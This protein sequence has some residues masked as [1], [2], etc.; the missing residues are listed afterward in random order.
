[1]SQPMSSI[2]LALLA[3]Q[4]RSEN[5]DRDY[6][7]A[8]PIA[9][10]GLSCRFPGGANSPELFWQLLASGIDA[11]TEVPRDRWD[12]DALYDPA[13]NVPG[14]MST[15]YGGFIDR[16]DE[17]DAAYFGIAP[18][19]AVR[20]DP[21][22]RLLLEVA[23]EALDDAGQTRERLAGT[24]AGVFIASYGDDYGHLLLSDRTVIDAHTGTGTAQSIV[25][26]RLSYLLNLQGPSLTID[27]ACSSS[28]VAVHLACQS[29]RHDECT[30]AMAGGVSL[31]LSPEMTIS[32]S[33]W[34]FMAP[35]GR[36]KT[37]DARADGFVRGEGCG[38]IVLK[39][40]SDALADGDRILALIR[41]SAVNQ[42]GR[43]TVLTAPNGLAQQA[44]I[45]QALDNAKLSPSQIT[46]I[47][48]HGTGTS[49]GDP[50]EVEALTEVYGQNRSDAAQV[51]LASVKTNIGHLEAA[52]GMAGL[53]KV[54]LCL[55]H[56]AIPPHLHFTQLNPH[57]SLTNTPFFIPTEMCAWPSTAQRRCAGI[58]SFG[59]GGTNAHVILEEAP[60]VPPTE[61]AEPLSGRAYLL[62]ISARHP[63]AVRALAHTYAE[64]L[65]NDARADVSD[66]CYT[67]SLR[68]TH[69]DY[70]LAVVGHSREELAE[71][72]TGDLP[73]AQ[74]IA[75]RP[76]LA[77][78]FTGQGA[79][80][81]AMGRELLDQEPVFR[82]TIE[83][84]SEL[85]KA[86]ASWSLWTELTRP[87]AD[88]RLDQTEIAQPAIFALQVALA[89]LWRSWGITPDVVVGH[90]VGEIAAA[91]IAGVLNLEDAVRVVF[92]RGRLMQRATGLGKMAAIELPAVEAE[93]AIAAYQDRLS[94]CGDQR[95]NL[96]HPFRRSRGA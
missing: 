71:R 25:A 16:V 37:F 23:Y 84:C 1:M 28:L 90:S 27:T 85:F 22:Q 49:L 82:D 24:R 17:F 78:V 9:V 21:Q 69:D 65:V 3:Q 94:R 44:V 42:D 39:R 54:I 47:E 51:A 87:E 13:P 6:V 15:R 58:S 50:I 57:I 32:L 46:Y 45:R 64:F 70:R 61:P 4:M 18:R 60:A 95:P 75:P 67:A 12:I 53:I 66:V 36:C 38:V 48:A 92:H 89:A 29:L 10:I 74:H 52:A 26:N 5:A 76:R 86:Y 83:R 62:P 91:H 2:K 31:I 80:W 72:L 96:C 7:R 33:K 55:Q 8:E 93:Q 63:D 34:G 68:R 59:F 56:E 19:E 79:Q 20:M 30:L 41:G 81:W 88:S 35:D 77:F 40:L 43:S 73:P 11:I 14:K